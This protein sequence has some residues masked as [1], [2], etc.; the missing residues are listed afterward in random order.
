MCSDGYFGEVTSGICKNCNVKCKTCI[1]SSIKCLTCTSNL[2][3]NDFDC[4]ENCPAG[5]YPDSSKICQNCDL[6]KCATCTNF[7]TC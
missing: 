4:L 2:N 7:T 5:K 1:T 3:Y 6:G